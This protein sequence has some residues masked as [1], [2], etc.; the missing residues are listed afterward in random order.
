M[1]EVFANFLSNNLLEFCSY[2]SH[3][4]NLSTSALPPSASTRNELDAVLTMLRK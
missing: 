3:K 1:E 4:K 2:D